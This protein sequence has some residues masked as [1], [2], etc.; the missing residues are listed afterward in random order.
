MRIRFLSLL[1][2]LAALS[3]L[4]PVTAVALGQLEV[5]AVD[6]ATNAGMVRFHVQFHNPGPS[7]SESASGEIHSQEYGAFLPDF[8]SIG[9]FNVPP[10]MP[11]SFFDVFIDVPLDVLPPSAPTITP[12]GN[13]TAA[14]ICGPDDRWGG[15]VDIIWTEA[16][17]GGGQVNVHYCD[18]LVCPGAGHSYVH[19][20][21]GC[22]GLITWSFSGI[23]PGWHVA[24]LNEDYTP[25]G[26]AL[27][28]GWTGFFD[29]WADASVPVG[30]TCCIMLNLTCDGVTVPVE[31][32][33]E[34]CDC[35]TVETESSIWGDV[36]SLYR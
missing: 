17:G 11:D 13:K 27:W 9:A 36:K 14:V 19:V 7:L 18:L 25:V 34:A 20:L 2:L 4:L 12:W 22:T 6:W 31:L 16:T 35:S 3:V 5:S 32:C 8:G 10:L 23:C 15:N 33:V 30:T 24:L 29:V 28:A 1:T 21:T 26:P